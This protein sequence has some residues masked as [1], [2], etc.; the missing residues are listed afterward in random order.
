VIAAINPGQTIKVKFPVPDSNLP[1]GPQTPI[2]VAVEP[3]KGEANVDN[4]SFDYPV[5]FTF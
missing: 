3:V 1:I 2:T 5:A 4:N